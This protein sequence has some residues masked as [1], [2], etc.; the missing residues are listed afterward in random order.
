MGYGIFLFFDFLSFT[1]LFMLPIYNPEQ[2]EGR[3]L[4]ILIGVPGKNLAE[5]LPL[6]HLLKRL[7]HQLER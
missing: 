1:K 6:D 3:L 7:G 2:L 4:L 5:V